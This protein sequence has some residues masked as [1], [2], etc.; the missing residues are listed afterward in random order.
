MNLMSN[1]FSKD[2]LVKSTHFY[3]RVLRATK[4]TVEIEIVGGQYGWADVVGQT[5]TATLRKNGAFVLKGD[6]TLCSSIH[7]IV[8]ADLVEWHAIRGLEWKAA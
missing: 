3:G 6:K 8:E 4:R 2:S 7:L 5:F 1:A